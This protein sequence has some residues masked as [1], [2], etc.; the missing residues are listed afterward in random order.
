M[1]D[2]HIKNQYGVSRIIDEIFDVYCKFVNFKNN[3]PEFESELFYFNSL[4]YMLETYKELKYKK[5]IK[6]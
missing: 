6:K 5:F 4:R 3:Y 2:C 1:V